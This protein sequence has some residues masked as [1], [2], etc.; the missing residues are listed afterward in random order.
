MLFILV[1]SANETPSNLINEFNFK[2][3]YVLFSTNLKRTHW[4]YSSPT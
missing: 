2:S 1:V 3:L 4:Y